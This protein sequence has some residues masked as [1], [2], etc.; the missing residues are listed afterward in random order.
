MG[1]YLLVDDSMPVNTGVYTSYIFG[2]ASLGYAEAS[3]K[4]A[5]EA[6]REPLQGGGTDYVVNRKYFVMHPRGIKWTGT[7]TGATASNTELATG[8]NWAKV[9]EN[10]NIKIVQFKHKINQV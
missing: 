6:G 8:T 2:N 9:W 5:A 1:H 7:P 3:P 10:K 4:N